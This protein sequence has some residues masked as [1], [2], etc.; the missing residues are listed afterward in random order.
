M[1]GINQT[2]QEIFILMGLVDLKEK[3]GGENG[4]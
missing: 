2:Y 3:D 1:P 4:N